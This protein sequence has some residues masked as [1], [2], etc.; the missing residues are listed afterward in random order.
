MTH[1]V[2]QDDE[3]DARRRADRFWSIELVPPD[4]A[5][6]ED[7]F[8]RDSE[9]RVDTGVIFSGLVELELR[10]VFVGAFVRELRALRAG[11]PP[12]LAVLPALERTIEAAIARGQ[13]DAIK[14]FPWGRG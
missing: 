5:L 13:H 2:A 11:V 7:A 8:R 3:R 4:R 14:R 12:A 9:L 1:Q 10:D 6:L